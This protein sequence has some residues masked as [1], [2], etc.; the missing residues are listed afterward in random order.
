MNKKNA[1]ITKRPHAF[2]SYAS[3]YNV[4]ILNSFNAGL[5]LKDNESAI[6]NK[7]IDFLTELK[8]FRFVTT[9]TLEF[10]RIESDDKTKYD[11]LRSNS[12]TETIINESDTDDVFKSIY[13]TIIS[14]I[15]K[16]LGKVS[17]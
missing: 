5:Q 2:K 15:Q 8:G 14:N 17:G 11:T 10:T 1:K 6:K 13:T 9:L 16:Y 12:K 4:E 7:L 3:S